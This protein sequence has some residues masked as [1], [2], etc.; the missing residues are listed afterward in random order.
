MKKLLTILF[1][2]ITIIANCQDTPPSGTNFKSIPTYSIKYYTVDSTI[3]VYKGSTYGWTAVPRNSWW[4]EI[5][6]IIGTDT[7]FVRVNN[8]DTVNLFIYK[9]KTDSI[10]NPG[11]FTNY[12]AT[13]KEDKSNKVTS[14]SGGSTD[15][16]YPSAKLAYDQLALKAPIDDPTFTTKITTPGLNIP[17]SATLNYFWQCTDAGTGAGA[18]TAVSTT[19]FNKGV[20]DANTN[21]PTLA[22]GTGTNGWYYTCNVAGTTDF[23]PGEGERL[24][25]F[26]VGDQAM[27]N[28]TIWQKIP[29][30]ITVNLT[31]PI[32]SVGNATSIASQTGTGTTFAMSVSPTFTGTVGA[33][34]ITATGIIRSSDEIRVYLDGSDAVTSGANF[35]LANSAATDGAIFQLN[36]SS[37]VDLWQ[38]DGGWYRRV[39]FQK[40]GNVGIGTTSPTQKLQINGIA[41]INQGEL[42]LGND[43]NIA[44]AA[45]L[46]YNSNGNLDITP[47][48]G[49]NTIF[50]AGNV[51][52]GTTSPSTKL[53][54]NGIITATGGTSTQ[55]NT[56]YTHSQIAA[57]TGVHISDGERA[58]WDSKEPW[59]DNP[60]TTGYVLSSTTAGARSWVPAQT[61]SLSN[62][63]ILVGN[64]SNLATA[65]TM[66]GDVT[67]TNAGV[68][69]IGSLKVTNGM[70]ATGIDAV[71]L[72]NGTVT[73]AEL[74]YINSITSNVQT[75]LNAKQASLTFGIANTNTV[76][77]NMVGVADNDYAKFTSSGLEG[78]SYSE[79]LSDIGAAATN[80]TMY[81][82]TT[83]VAINRA[84]AGLTLA[85][86]TL[87]TPILGT[88]TS[89][90]LTN[91][92]FPDSWLKNNANDATDYTLTAANFILSSDRRLKTNIK[93][94]DTKGIDIEYKQFEMKSDRGQIRYGILAQDLQKTNPELVR[95][96]QD[97]ILS[98]AYIDLLI[99][100]IASL[101]QRVTE[102]E[103]YQAKKS[104]RHEK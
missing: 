61:T 11:Y 94:I 19:Q 52:I 2:F 97:G 82:G 102:L 80:Q 62:G 9:L 29:V 53:D 1:L 20:W 32:T 56:A 92:T 38:Y 71:K 73:N 70:V 83:G 40:D 47:R 35:H 37:G 93:P 54:I 77:I 45:K 57:G 5:T 95:E 63:K 36:A 69:A 72:A 17:T 87:T 90:I 84:S 34:A 10:T 33:A 25:T 7:T 104:R 65:V 49:Y 64:V 98:V 75:Q 50:T 16:Q 43:N 28:G 79:V 66:A 41:F 46:D 6:N 103:K 4:T 89:G 8:H 58:D 74:Q 27:Y 31:G 85:G 30:S 51:G 60:G 26:A 81:I 15:I 48:S 91:C 22:D 96:D 14:L 67:I 101:K 3:W 39:T 13:L 88:P 100:E 24:L 42:Y 86:I 99:K 44:Y 12:K 23:D 55:W 76:Q 18:W 21:T 78:R 68:S 59:L